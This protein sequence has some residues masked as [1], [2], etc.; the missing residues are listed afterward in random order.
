MVALLSSLVFLLLCSLFSS[1]SLTIELLEVYPRPDGTVYVCDACHE[2]PP[3]PPSPSDIKVNKSNTY[4]T[5]RI[6][7]FHLFVCVDEIEAIKAIAAKVSSH[8]VDADVE[9]EQACYLPLS[10]DGVPIIGKVRGDGGRRGS[11]EKSVERR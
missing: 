2:N 3:L 5:R 9:A 10:P 4:L 7:I 8:L 1:L 6:V 11:K